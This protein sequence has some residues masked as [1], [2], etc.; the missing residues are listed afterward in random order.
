MFCGPHAGNA[1]WRTSVAKCHTAT[2][3]TLHS[4]LETCENEPLMLIV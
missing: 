3:F 4:K 2:H 1:V